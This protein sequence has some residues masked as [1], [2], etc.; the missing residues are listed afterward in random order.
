[1]LPS[2]SPP[3]SARRNST[4][5]LSC[6]LKFVAELVDSLKDIHRFET[7]FGFCLES[8]KACVQRPYRPLNELICA[9]RLNDSGIEAKTFG[10]FYREFISAH[11]FPSAYMKNS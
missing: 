5:V 6:R 1:M 3:T 2:V 11:L 9:D 4:S 8:D 10:N 7:E